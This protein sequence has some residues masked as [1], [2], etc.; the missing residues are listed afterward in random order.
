MLSHPDF[1]SELINTIKTIYPPVYLSSGRHYCNQL[2]NPMTH[3]IVLGGEM[4][5]GYTYICA[6]ISCT[7]VV[8][9]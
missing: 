1:K 8:L 6:V 5:E 4:V 2:V 9:D 3:C 7:Y